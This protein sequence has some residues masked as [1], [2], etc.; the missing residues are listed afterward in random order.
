MALFTRSRL[1]GLLF[2]LALPLEGAAALALST[3]AATPA[4]GASPALSLN[5]R[6]ERIADA[7]RERDP[8]ATAEAIPDGALSYMFV[9]AP[10]VG[11]GNGGFRNGGFYNGGFRNGGFYN[12]GFRNGGF[13]NGGFRNG[14]GWRNGGFRN[15]GFR[16]AW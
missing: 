8:E 11:W 5:E 6:L 2:L 4:E 12:G 3:A 16:N 13:Y 1:F 14:G 15:G 10:A 7:V 9:N